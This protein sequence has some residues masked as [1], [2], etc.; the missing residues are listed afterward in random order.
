MALLS[1]HLPGDRPSL[2]PI[3]PETVERNK[4]RDTCTAYL[5]FHNYMR[6]LL[7]IH[8]PREVPT[9]QPPKRSKTFLLP[10]TR[11]PLSSPFLFLYC[12]KREHPIESF[13]K[14]LPLFAT[15]PFTVSRRLKLLLHLPTPPPP[16]SSPLPG[17]QI[18]PVGPA[19]SPPHCEDSKKIPRGPPAPGYN[20]IRGVSCGN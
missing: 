12:L 5:C 1:A 15:S 20:E 11:T 9:L 16:S 18:P 6:D 7:L 8:P 13:R 19:T 2:I 17:F 10:L 3:A 4:R 14:N